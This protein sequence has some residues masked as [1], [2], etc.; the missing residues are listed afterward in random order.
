VLRRICEHSTKGVVMRQ[1]CEG[2]CSMAPAVD[3]SLFPWKMCKQ[4]VKKE[5]GTRRA[6]D[7]GGLCAPGSCG[8]RSDVVWPVTDMFWNCNVVFK[9]IVD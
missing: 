2:T 9:S 3:R 1:I 4:V 8:A 7:D 5:R 6:V